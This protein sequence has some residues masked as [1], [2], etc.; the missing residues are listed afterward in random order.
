MEIEIESVIIAFSLV[1]IMISGA[2]YIFCCKDKDTNRIR[3][4]ISI[5]SLNY[6]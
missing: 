3:T 5:E 2:V 4:T 6:D 1:S